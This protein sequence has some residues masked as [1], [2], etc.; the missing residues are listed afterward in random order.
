MQT[1]RQEEGGEGWRNRTQ[2]GA[3]EDQRGKRGEMGPEEER[4]GVRRGEDSVRKNQCDSMTPLGVFS[5]SLCVLRGR[6]QRP[7]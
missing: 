5:V 4:L 6:C 7:H 3:G 1:G 2:G